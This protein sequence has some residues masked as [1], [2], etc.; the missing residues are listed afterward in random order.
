MFILKY[1]PFWYASGILHR[2]WLDYVHTKMKTLVKDEN[3]NGNYISL[4]NNLIPWMI[5]KEKKKLT[6]INKEMNKII[7]LKQPE[8]N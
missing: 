4:L 3:G 2:A 7:N 6:K 8:K 5:L 1:N